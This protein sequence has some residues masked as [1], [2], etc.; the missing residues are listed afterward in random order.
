MAFFPERYI[1]GADKYLDAY[2]E[3][4]TIAWRS[5]SREAMRT[6]EI[7]LANT[8]ATD[9]TIFSCGNGGSAAISNHL[10]CDCLKGVQAG[11]KLKPRVHSLSSTPE[12]ITAIAN[13]IGVE[14]I[15]SLPLRSLGRTG[16]VLIAISSSGASPNIVS[17]VR[18]AKALGMKVIGLTGFDGGHT[19]IEADISLHVTA[20]NYG[21]I[22]D[23]HQSLMHVLAQSLRMGALI[24]HTD[25][26]RIRF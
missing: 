2:V 15:F 21:V 10:L 23:V 12:L 19:A 25:L 1:M 14:E 26:G 22:E 16:D 13:D 17:A 6:A 20:N 5:V 9:S 11:T 4:L 18:T 3:E 7:L 8:V 24:S